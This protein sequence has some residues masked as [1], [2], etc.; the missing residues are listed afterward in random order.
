MVHLKYRLPRNS[1]ITA[2]LDEELSSS[3]IYTVRVK[4]GWKGK[5]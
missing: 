4:V 3:N 5:E 2:L 1:I